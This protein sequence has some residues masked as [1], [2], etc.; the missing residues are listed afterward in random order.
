MSDVDGS[1]ENFGGSPFLFVASDTM[2]AMG[3][4]PCLIWEIFPKSLNQLVRKYAFFEP[5]LL[6]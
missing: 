2:K 1:D 4:Q 6:I 3:K 5:N